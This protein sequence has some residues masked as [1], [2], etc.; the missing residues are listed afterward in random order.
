MA[1]A[2]IIGTETLD[3]NSVRTTDVKHDTGGDAVETGPL[4]T[5]PG[6][7]S[8]PMPQDYALVVTDQ[9][10][11]GRVVAASIDP[12]SPRELAA[13]ES[14]VYSRKDDRTTA[15]SI[16]LETNGTITARNDNIRAALSE[17]GAATI[18]NDNITAEISESGA[19]TVENSSGHIKLLDDGIVEINGVRF[20]TSGN[21]SNAKKID[22]E[23]A[24]L[25]NS[26]KADS[27]EFTSSLK[28]ANKELNGHQHNNGNPK[29][30]PNL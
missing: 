18:V 11:G 17:A 3:I 6:F 2:K 22:A 24:E 8:I 21:I 25:S 4:F 14:L 27:G 15:A 28:V 7:E 9:R 30:G 10:T 20:D 26:L 5:P 19:F 29:T 13:G 23:D 16:K 12:N 1:V